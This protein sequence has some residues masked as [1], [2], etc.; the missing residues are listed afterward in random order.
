MTIMCWISITLPAQ[1][2]IFSSSEKFLF[3]WEIAPSYKSHPRGHCDS[4]QQAPGASVSNP[5][6]LPNS[7][8][9]LI[10]KWKCYQSQIKYSL[11]GDIFELLELGK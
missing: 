9:P 8:P 1:N 11:S 2:S 4:P 7:H 10:Q 6:S 5:S 3:E